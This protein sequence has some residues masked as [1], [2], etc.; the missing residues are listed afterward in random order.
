MTVRRFGRDR[1]AARAP[2]AALA[3]AAFAMGLAVPAQAQ[4]ED[5]SAPDST[6]RSGRSIDFRL[7]PADDG[8]A[9][10]MQGPSDNG[11]PPLAPGERAGAPPP[12]RTTPAPQPSAPRAVPTQPPAAARATSA[13]S[14]EP[15]QTPRP[16]AAPRAAEPRSATGAA[17]VSP[18]LPGEAPPASS[19]PVEEES[20]P[21]PAT[22]S[23]AADAPAT[24]A[25]ARDADGAPLWAWLLAGL[26]ALGA[27]FWYWR[28]RSVSVDTA[29]A[30]PLS[31]PTSGPTPEPAPEPAPPLPARAPDPAQRAASPLVMRPAD[32]LRAR[33]AMTLEIDDIHLTAEQV[34]VAFSLHLVNRGLAAATGLMIR[35]ALGQGSAMPEA[36]LAR[37]FDGAGG[38]VLRDDI[39]LEPGAGE[40]LSG[41]V[42]LPRALIEPLTIGGRPM[43]VP[44]M[45]L[46]VTYH[47][48]GPG[49]AFGQNAGSFVLGR[50]QGE[51]GGR[52]A[53]VPLGRA[54]HRVAKPGQRATAMRREQ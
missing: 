40:R 27:G 44:V 30:E 37:F 10:G 35:I 6:P 41:E 22:P 21:S 51:G 47:W 14:P 17:P 29:G 32:E 28:R 52:L 1:T 19:S 13:P 38:S 46:D 39:A 15:S 45:A 4:Q 3:I 50:E 36:V 8:R 26:A 20:A 25:P 12:A 34:A 48:D 2:G 54:E 53:P 18:S 11:L 42:M 24:A 9:P 23:S 7:P 33:V 5:A 43:L 31:V 49:E 16:A